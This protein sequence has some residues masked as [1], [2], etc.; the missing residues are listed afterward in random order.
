MERKGEQTRG[1]GKKRRGVKWRVSLWYPSCRCPAEPPVA[2]VAIG[3]AGAKNAGLLAVAILAIGD[4]AL[5]AR[6]ASYRVTMAREVEAA[7]RKP[8]ENETAGG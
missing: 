8:C 5:R 7:D 1:H 4:K 2:T 3:K 6:L